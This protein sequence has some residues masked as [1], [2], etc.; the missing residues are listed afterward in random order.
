MNTTPSERIAQQQYMG[1]ADHDPPHLPPLPSPLDA[2][3]LQWQNALINA[4]AS[5]LPSEAH[6]FS[7]LQNASRALGFTHTSCIFQASLP[8]G[9]PQW[10]WLNDYPAAWQ[11]QYTDASHILHDPR[12]RQARLTSTPFYWDHHFFEAIPGLWQSLNAHGIGYGWTQSML[13]EPGGIS[14][15]TLSRATPMSTAELADRQQHLAWLGLLGHR[16]LA[17]LMHTRLNRTAPSLT[18]REV[19]VLRW[20]ADGKSAQDIAEILSLSKNTVDFHI[21]NAIVKLGVANKTAA[22]VRA[23]LLGLFQ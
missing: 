5:D 23:M 7:C 13:D 10:S 14:L 18:Q 4:L 21:R 2:A 9:N 15:L 3:T 6:I 20:T 8:V 11:Q 16:A 22:V 12:M 17:R 19:E 1:S